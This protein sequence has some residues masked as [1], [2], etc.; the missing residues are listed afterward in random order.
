MV[1]LRG[2][3]SNLWSLCLLAVWKTMLPGA[4]IVFNTVPAMVL[5]AQ[6]LV[7]MK[8]NSLIIDLASAPGGTDFVRLRRWASG[9]F[10]PLA[11]RERLLRRLR[12]KF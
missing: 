6:L 1:I 12:G 5:N 4:D 9:L 7:K 11:F 2:F 3:L 8:K 10:W